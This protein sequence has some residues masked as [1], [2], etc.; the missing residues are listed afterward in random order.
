[1]PGTVPATT[2]PGRHAWTR[3]TERTGRCAFQPTRVEVSKPAGLGRVHVEQGRI[4]IGYRVESEPK[5]GRLAA[6]TTPARTRRKEGHHVF[7]EAHLG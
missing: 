5:L 3:E 4:G 7:S 6:V 1:M 2:A